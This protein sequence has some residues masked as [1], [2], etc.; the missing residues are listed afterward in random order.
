MLISA[1]LSNLYLLLEYFEFDIL[2]AGFNTNIFKAVS[3]TDLLRLR[4]K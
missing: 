4:S 1:K 2:K 3:T